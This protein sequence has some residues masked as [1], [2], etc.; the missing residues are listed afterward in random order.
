IRLL[1]HIG[2]HSPLAG[3]KPSR[4]VPGRAT[5][6]RS[7]G[8]TAS[9]KVERKRVK[10]SMA[11]LFFGYP[12]AG[13]KGNATVLSWCKA[14]NLLA[15]ATD[16]GRVSIH[17]RDGEVVDAT[18][19]V[20]EGKQQRVLAV[21]LDWQP[22]TRTLAVG[23]A[24]GQ[25]S[26]WN[27]DRVA[28]VCT[29]SSVHRHAVTVLQWDP[30]GARLV[31]GDRGGTVCMWKVDGRGGITSA[32]QHR[33]KSAITAAVCCGSRPPML[34]PFF[35]GTEAGHVCFADDAGHCTE[36]QQLT[37]AV[38]SLVFHER[39]V[40]LVVLTRGLLMTQLRMCED[41]RIAQH[42]KAKL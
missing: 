2:A 13:S 42:M 5:S 4:R 28:C 25:V 7:A 35:F 26:V 38:D 33:R 34:P 11:S 41:G 8:I 21:A 40:R 19:I 32:V 18:S 9:R 20:R 23:W 31:T 12:T 10:Q 39:A 37:S 27:T 24:D 22:H 14:A 1:K 15:V 17:S 3:F 36:V 6:H 29:N 16:D 30:A